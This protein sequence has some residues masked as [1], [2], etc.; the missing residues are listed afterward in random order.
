MEQASTEAPSLMS[1]KAQQEEPDPS[2]LFAPDQHPEH[3]LLPGIRMF[4]A[5]LDEAR[6]GYIVD[7]LGEIEATLRL[8]FNQLEREGIIQVASASLDPFGVPDVEFAAN[9]ALEQRQLTTPRF[10]PPEVEE[11]PEDVVIPVV[12]VDS[13][14]VLICDPA[15]I[16]SGALDLTKPMLATDDSG[17]FQLHSMKAPNV[18]LAVL[19]H[20]PFGDGSFPVYIE[21][22]EDGS[23][24]GAVLVFQEPEQLAALAD[25]VPEPAEPDEQDRIDE[26]REAE[27]LNR[28]DSRTA[29]EQEEDFAPLE[30]GEP[31]DPDAPGPDEPEP[32]GA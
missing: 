31:E 19:V 30:E 28:G 18:P 23:K 1:P 9:L 3:S 2:D 20:T 21:D 7:R 13:G 17:V 26:V 14:Q 15:H 10:T 11:A 32:M 27:A 4:T 6:G 5:M 25:A 24:A 16:S 12:G 29:A 8:E 22:A